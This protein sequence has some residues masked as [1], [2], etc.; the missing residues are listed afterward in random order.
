MRAPSLLICTLMALCVVGIASNS[1]AA[2]T[3][4]VISA[5][6][7]RDFGETS[8]QNTAFVQ[9]AD[10]SN[11]L[12]FQFIGGANFSLVAN[13]T[14]WWEVEFWCEAGTYHIWARGKSDGNVGTDSFWLQFDDQIGTTEHTADL[15]FMF[16]GLGNWRDVVDA[17]IYKWLSQGTPPLT[18]V[19]WKAKESGLHRVRAQ[20]RQQPHFLDQLL[21]SQDQ[22]EQPD[23]D[24]WPT[25]FP[26]KDPRAIESEG[27]LATT[28]D[29]L[30]DVGNLSSLVDA[31][32][33][34]PEGAKARLGKGGI[35]D[36]QYSPDGTRLAVAGGIGIWLYDTATHQVENSR[37]GE[38]ALLTGH[39]GI[40][41]SVAFSPDGETL[42]SGSDD[43]TVRLWDANTGQHN[44]TLTGHTGRVESVAFSPDGET[45]ASGSWDRTVR[46]WDAKTGQHKVTLRGHTDLVWS[47]AF[48]P[49][50]ET[51]ASGG[52][53]RDRTVRLWDA[54][55]G[56]PNATL[57]GHTGGV[58]SVVFS[59]DGATLASGSGDSTVRLWDVA[60][61]QEKAT[62]RG[63]TGSVW[64]V[65]FS[66]DGQT[67]ASGSWQEVRLWD[68]VTGQHNAT[69]TGRGV[70]SVAYSPD[71]N[72]IASSGDD[73]VRLW[74]A[75]TGQPKAIITGHTNGVYS[76]AYSLD[77]NTLASG[78]SHGTVRLWDAVTGQPKAT[79]TG[80]TGRVLSVVFSSDGNTI[81]SASGD[82]TVR[83]WEVVTGQ[84]KATL[85]GHTGDVWSVA[86][87]PDGNTIASGGGYR[88][89]TVRLW[90]AVTGQPKATLTGHTGGVSNVAFSPDGETIASGSRD[91]TVLLWD[92]DTG[93]EKATLTGHTGGVWSIAFSPDGETIA[94]GGGSGDNTLRLWDAVTGQPKATLTGHT[95][96]VWSVA[97][98]P[99]GNTI[100]SG[101][102]YRDNTVRLWDADTGQ[103]KATL[104]GHTAEVYSVAFSPDGATL[105]SGSDD[106]TVLLW[107]IT[108]SAPTEP[109]QPKADVNGDNVV[110]ILDLVLVGSNFGKTG[111]NDADI[112]GDGVV[113]IVDLVL[114][115]GALGNAAAAPSAHPQALAMLTAADV[116]GWLTQAQQMALTDPA[117]LR[118]IAMLEQLLAAMTPAETVLL[119]NYP[120]P[121][122]PETWIPYHLAH[123]A[124]V[125]VTIY[126]TKGAPVRQL[127]LGHQPV[128]YYTDRT[129]AAYWDGRN[130]SGEQVASGVYFYQLRV[131]DYTALRRMVILK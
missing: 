127:D 11:G 37:N 13:P 66:P 77:G 43:G 24:P 30:K 47:V 96:G 129:K 112:N 116:E 100:A 5:E 28:W 17:G 2:I 59:S 109:P 101:G 74:D 67:L 48:S 121:F 10:A 120:N 9:D 56:Q 89:N 20:P 36:L 125:T 14:A 106:G 117:Y 94:S 25:E 49:D 91:G 80:H 38:V 79:L 45:L 58:Y 31:Q 34:L 110:N 93:Q 123:A 54:R 65:A 70:W 12:A 86:F 126:D 97:F 32:L 81:A 82:D 68:A 46:L 71:G 85:T 35:G 64:S 51:I 26:R 63:H 92:A 55:T 42:A 104:T 73:T 3:E 130:D 57:R 111:Q 113:N 90:D 98:S 108:P 75:V 76:V 18:V 33:N 119:P 40:V 52:Y 99:D 15:D 95:H 19:E 61:G 69:L 118:G 131:G 29:A 103:H 124:D 27:T 78:S 53:Y 84:H 7:I 41:N 6:T 22:D 105:A 16:R 23:D 44:A 4:V 102:G 107:E 115:A 88:D 72:T 114:V 21:L 8:P 60:T 39:T 87:S 122:N 83:L 62:L 1:F 50:G 128:G